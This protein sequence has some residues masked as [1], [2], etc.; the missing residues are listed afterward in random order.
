MKIKGKVKMTQEGFVIFD[1]S[2][3]FGNPKSA[4]WEN[5]RPFRVTGGDEYWKQDKES[6][7]TS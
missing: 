4:C 6:K 2:I 5:P 3:A 1:A 7:F